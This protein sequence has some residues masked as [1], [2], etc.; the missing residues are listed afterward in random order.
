MNQRDNRRGGI[1]VGAT[2][3]AV[4]SVVA[5][6]VVG[7]SD[8][9]DRAAQRDITL[10]GAADWAQQDLID[11]PVGSDHDQFLND[12]A[13]QQSAYSWALEPLPNGG[14]GMADDALLF[15]GNAD[16]LDQ[17]LVQAQLDQLLGAG[18]GG[19]AGG[20]AIL[21]GQ[22]LFDDL[23]GIA[24]PP[25]SVLSV[26]VTNLIDPGAYAGMGGFGETVWSVPGDL[27]QAAWADLF[28]MFSLADVAP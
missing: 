7:I 28:G 8:Q 21:S 2:T 1:A 13:L 18:Q 26:D 12:V 14:F 3:L 25:G 5:M 10:V 17:A 9:A 16:V 11:V 22:Q 20:D 19:D 24:I 6:G 15:D 27:M 4:L 23:S